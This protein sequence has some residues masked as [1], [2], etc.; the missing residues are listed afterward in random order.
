MRP[1]FPALALAL[2]LLACG[3][4][5]A[6]P[7][8]P[9]NGAGSAA[10]AAP[11]RGDWM[12]LHLLSD[13]ES[14]NP[15]TSNDAS[16]A[17]ILSR[18]FPSLLT[19]DNETLDQRPVIA[20]ALPEISEDKLTYTFR[21]RTD[22]TYSDGKP[23]VA[24][25][26]V[27][28]LKAIKHP[29]V[30]APHTRNYYM[31]VR[32]AVAVDTHTVRFD[33]RERYFLNDLV[34]GG[35]SPLPRH[36]YDPEG[37]LDGISVA[38]LD[39]YEGLDSARKERAKRFAERFNT[40]FHRNPLGP[41]AYALEQSERDY[42]TGQRIV[43]RHRD[44]FWAPGDAHAGDGYVDRVVYR[45]V[46]DMEAAL[47]AFKGGELDLFGLTP[48]QHRR[49]DTNN[50]TFLARA[51]KKE[52]TSPSYSYIGWNGTR[53]QFKDVRVRQALR[54]FVDTRSMI[55]KILFGLG[56]P[57]ESPIFVRRP[58]YNWS[59]PLHEF[60]PAKGKALL[61]EAGWTDSDGDG[62]LDN[63]VA[64]ARTPLRFEILIN[65]GNTTRKAVGLTVIDELKRA[66]IDASVRELDWSIFLNKVKSFDYDAVILGWQMGVTPPDAYQIWHSSQAVEG[67]SNHVGYKNPEVDRILEEYRLEFDPAKRKALYD[68]FQA[69][70]WRDQPYAFLFMTKAIMSWDRRFQGV[71][72]YPSEN[73][74]LNE[75]WVPRERQRYRE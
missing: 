46:N 72:W 60:D 74:E 27:F 9:P 18:I 21:L 54:C 38:D 25:D 29:E 15:I 49:P 4:E 73:T 24:E 42:V 51:E 48:L 31:S 67:G 75:W 63:D 45:I 52:L 32:D 1:A 30:L 70:L 20:T 16:S 69:I 58:E 33:L 55:E 5:P 61:A 41:G 2:F 13:P 53:P 62:L 17:Q 35:L 10:P 14:L 26:V 3:S 66:G 65:S 8:E 28:G 7:R 12:V 43:L 36:Y 59:L 64:G 11:V 44:D 23:V 6:A 22:A 40:G 34:L 50:E 57:V 68:R 37:L 19:L 71:R 56:E 47:V 39:A